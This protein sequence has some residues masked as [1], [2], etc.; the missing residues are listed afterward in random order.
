[1][2]L[3]FPSCNALK[4]EIRK[5]TVVGMAQ[6]QP[7]GGGGGSVEITRFRSS[8]LSPGLRV[9]LGAVHSTQPRNNL[10]NSDL[11]LHF[12]ICV[13]YKQSVLLNNFL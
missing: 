12:T 13:S 7:G 3:D 10:L 4:R 9:F 5:Q 11:M 8:S 6:G 2:F 1:M